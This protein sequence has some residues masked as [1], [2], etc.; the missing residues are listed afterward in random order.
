MLLGCHISVLLLAYFVTV[1]HDSNCAIEEQNRMTEEYSLHF[2]YWGEI[3]VNGKPEFFPPRRQI[4]FFAACQPFAD[5]MRQEPLP[6]LPDMTMY[7]FFF[8]KD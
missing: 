1:D 6:T 8:C 5:S 3:S 2:F 7:F 4:F